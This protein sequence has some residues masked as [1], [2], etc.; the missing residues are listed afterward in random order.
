MSCSQRNVRAN[1][2]FALFK[3]YRLL[4]AEWTVNDLCESLQADTTSVRKAILAWI[5]HGVLREKD[6][7]EMSYAL[8][9]EAYEEGIVASGS[10][11]QLAQRQG[12]CHSLKLVRRFC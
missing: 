8:L 1:F 12:N 7:S 6:S 3:A 10:R 2:V 9:E 5:D 11:R 4:E